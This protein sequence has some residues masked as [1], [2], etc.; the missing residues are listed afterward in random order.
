MKLDQQLLANK[1]HIYNMLYRKIKHL[2]GVITGDGVEALEISIDKF[3]EIGKDIEKIISARN[4]A[5]YTRELYDD[6]LKREIKTLDRI[7]AKER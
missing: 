2:S 1:I 6:V 4:R 7:K 5:N 3:L